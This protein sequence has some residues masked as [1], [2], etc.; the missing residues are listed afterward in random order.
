[1]FVNFLWY[2]PLVIVR[3]PALNMWNYENDWKSSADTLYFHNN[4][5][6][7]YMKMTEKTEKLIHI[8]KI[9]F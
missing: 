9:E 6:V 1:M 3:Y 8:D 4:Q 2:L 5:A 7:G